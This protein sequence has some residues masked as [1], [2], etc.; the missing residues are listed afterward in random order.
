MPRAVGPVI[1]TLIFTILVPG[2]VAVFV[3]HRLV[4]SAHKPTLGAIE[5]VGVVLI[6]LGAA[7]YFRCAWDFA[8]HGLGTP[9]PIDPPKILVSRGLHRFV[10]NPM[11]VG[12]L[13]VVF[14]QA[15]LFRSV[16]IRIYGVCL[17]LLFHL[18]VVLYEEPTLRQQFGTEYEEYCKAVPRWMPR[19]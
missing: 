4:S 2:F 19:V 10:R 8:Y 18:F 16:R 7:I 13:S 12:V 14:G 6:G 15:A 3:P 9:A 17:W 1:K 11:Y 5:L